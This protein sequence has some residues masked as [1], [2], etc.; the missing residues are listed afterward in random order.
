MEYKDYYKVLS[1][2][3]DASAREIKTA[4]RSLA[5]KFHPDTNPD[6]P[7]AESALKS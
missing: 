3:R 2:A 5:K 6:N 4:F 1:V 7:E